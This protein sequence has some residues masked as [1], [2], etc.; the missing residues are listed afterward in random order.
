MLIYVLKGEFLDEYLEVWRVFVIACKLFC[1][2]FVI[3]SDVMEVDSFLKIF[4]VKFERFYGV[5]RVISN[6]Y[7]YIYFCECVLDFGFVYVFWFF[8]FERYNGIMGSF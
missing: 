4:C 1:R 5:E 2:I 7:M 6:M 3:V 8:F